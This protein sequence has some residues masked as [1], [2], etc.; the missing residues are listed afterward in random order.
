MGGWVGGWVGTWVRGVG[1]SAVG[2]GEGGKNTCVGFEGIARGDLQASDDLAG[3]SC[4]LVAR[5]TGVRRGAVIDPARRRC[6]SAGA[7]GIAEDK[8]NTMMRVR[9]QRIGESVA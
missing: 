1:G 3:A 6:G 5:A 8:E 9:G 2:R 7:D 4:R